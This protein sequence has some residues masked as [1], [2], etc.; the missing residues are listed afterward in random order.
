MCVFAILVGHLNSTRPFASVQNALMCFCQSLQRIATSNGRCEVGLGFAHQGDVNRR[1]TKELQN[2]SSSTLKQFALTSAKPESTLLIRESEVNDFVVNFGRIRVRAA[3]AQ[4]QGCTA[5]YVPKAQMIIC[6][7]MFIYIRSWA[8]HISYKVWETEV[9]EK[10]TDFE[11][12][13]PIK[14][15]IEAQPNPTAQSSP[16]QQPRPAQQSSLF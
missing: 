5:T 8:R 10:I 14:Y 4:D 3:Q 7:T 11:G 16:A 1:I 15:Q 6:G 2:C 9:H 13:Q 12:L